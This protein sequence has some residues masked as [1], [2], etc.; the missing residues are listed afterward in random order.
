MD[1]RSQISLIIFSLLLLAGTALSILALKKSQPLEDVTKLR[2]AMFYEILPDGR[3]QCHLCPNH[4]VLDEGQVGRCGVRKNIGGKFYS[5]VFGKPVTINIDPIEKKPFYHFLPGQKTYSIATVGCPL[6]CRYCQNWDIAQRE[7]KDVESYQMTPEEVV[8][9]AQKAGVEVISFTYSEPVAFYEYMLA[10][11]QEAQKQGIR[12]T[13]V[14]SGYINP[15]PLKTL[16]PFLD[17]VKIDL[18]A[19]EE[20][21]YQEIVGGHLGPVLKALKIVQQS[22]THL[23]IVN[24]LIPGLN[25]SDEEVRAMAIWIKENLGTDIPLHFSRFHPDYLMKDSPPTPL[26]TV[27]R[28]RWIA[29]E[30]GLKYVYTGNVADEEGSTTF[31]SG[32]GAPLIR[33]KGYFVVE[34]K[35]GSDGWTPNCPHRIYGVW[36]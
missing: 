26:E 22:G 25:D 20:D 12:T 15:E 33:R 17:A 5:L 8:S 27:K 21:F 9:A 24:L 13:M 16:L 32:N 34:N 4:C 14:S 10:I 7:P 28:A 19:F 29:Q 11:A 3:V 35:I 1:K 30:V 23:E 18:K 31:C 6:S 36:R 2:E